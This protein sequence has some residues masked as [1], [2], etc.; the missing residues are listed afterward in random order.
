MKKNKK[1][2]YF[3]TFYQNYDTIII[4]EGNGK[5]YKRKE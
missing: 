3:M 2:V 5:K 1:K 4:G